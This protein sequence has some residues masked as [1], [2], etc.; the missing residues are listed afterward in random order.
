MN[1]ITIFCTIVKQNKSGVAN[2]LLFSGFV[3]AV[4]T[5]NFN[6]FQN[7]PSPSFIGFAVIT[8]ICID[9]FY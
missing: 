8:A 2:I 7:L 5:F 9:F 4:V 1:N 3:A 6:F